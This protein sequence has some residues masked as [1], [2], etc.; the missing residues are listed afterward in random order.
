MSTDHRAVAATLTD[1]VAK[2]AQPG[3]NGL[4][5]A[6]PYG[7]AVTAQA[8]TTHALLAVEAR[9]GELV[10]QQRTAN[11]LAASDSDLFDGRIDYP[12]VEYELRDRI[13]DIIHPAE[14]G[15]PE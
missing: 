15:Q 10:E 13:D 5:P 1:L 2:A 11:L 9:L 8:A 3:V 7:L 4:A 6:D 14:K 12:A